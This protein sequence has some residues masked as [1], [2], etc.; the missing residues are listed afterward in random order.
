MMSPGDQHLVGR[1]PHIAGFEKIL[2]D[3]FPQSI[4]S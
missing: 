1:Y 4:K 3:R 2:T